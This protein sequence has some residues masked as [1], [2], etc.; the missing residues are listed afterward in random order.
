MWFV[1][2]DV[3]FISRSY[4]LLT[5]KQISNLSSFNDKIQSLNFDIYHSLIIS[6]NCHILSHWWYKIFLAFSGLVM[7]GFVVSRSTISKVS[8]LRRAW[9]KCRLMYWFYAEYVENVPVFC[10]IF[11]ESFKARQSWSA[12]GQVWYH[13]PEAQEK[14]GRVGVA[15]YM[16][17]G[18]SC[19]VSNR[20]MEVGF[21]M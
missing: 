16:K 17:T 7:F 13:Q 19:P 21:Y 2:C 5:T 3:S 15:F 10:H 18:V 20:Y 8:Y 1:V 6:I 12:V 14:L 9:I 11:L 4:F